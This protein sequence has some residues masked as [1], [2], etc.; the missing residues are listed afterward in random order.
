MNPANPLIPIRSRWHAGHSVYDHV[1]AWIAA[2][3]EEGID[4]SIWRITGALACRAG[5]FMRALAR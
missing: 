3:Q 1:L 5:L 4:V 2:L